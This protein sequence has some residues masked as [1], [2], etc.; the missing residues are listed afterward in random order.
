MGWGEGACNTQLRGR[1]WKGQDLLKKGLGDPRSGEKCSKGGRRK[2]QA[3]LDKT[4]QGR[5]KNTARTDWAKKRRSYKKKRQRPEGLKDGDSG[6]ATKGRA[7]RPADLLARQRAKKDLNSG[8]GKIDRTPPQDD[9]GREKL[10][11][12]AGNLGIDPRAVPGQK[13]HFAKNRRRGRTKGARPRKTVHPTMG[14][15]ERGEGPFCKSLIEL[16]NG[17]P[18]RPKSRRVMGPGERATRVEE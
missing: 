3:V 12:N 8:K 10:E 11:K 17:K 16:R 6:S 7:P 13:G 14:G 18:C 15:G 2:G 4:E 9:Q 5:Y 1:G